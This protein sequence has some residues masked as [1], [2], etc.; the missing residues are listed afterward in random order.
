MRY[1][2]I[3]FLLLSCES[4]KEKISR[5]IEKCADE[6]FAAFVTSEIIEPYL[7]EDKEYKKK[8]DEIYTEAYEYRKRPDYNKIDEIG[9]YK[10]SLEKNKILSKYKKDYTEQLEFEMKIS[11]IESFLSDR[12]TLIKKT[13]K[14]MPLVKKRSFE[15]P[16]YIS[17]FKNCENENSVNPETF[18]L[19]YSE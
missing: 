15:T 3:L 19:K 12:E 10:L 18:K 6:Y 16:N 5:N 17:F 1:L 7:L 2:F 13:I 14:E 4:E 11:R 9:I 8:F